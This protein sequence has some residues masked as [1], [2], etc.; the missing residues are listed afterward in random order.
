MIASEKGSVSYPSDFY[1][2]LGK[3]AKIHHVLVSCGSDPMVLLHL[4][5]RT[6][7]WADIHTHRLSLTYEYGHPVFVVDM[8]LSS[9]FS[10]FTG[11]CQQSF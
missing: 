10:S 7:E 9:V 2:D 6:C 11:I 3:I 5:M 1:M 8:L 4:H